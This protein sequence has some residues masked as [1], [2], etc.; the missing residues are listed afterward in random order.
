MLTLSSIIF[1][2]A[3]ILPASFQL[4]LA[5]F[6]GHFLCDY[7]LQGAFLAS[8]K[9]RHTKNADTSC[10]TP[11]MWIHALTAHSF[12]HGGMVWI[13]TGHC[14]LG[15]MEIALHWLIDFGKSEKWYSLNT[16]QMLHLACKCAYCLWIAY[17]CAA[18]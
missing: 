1:D 17:Y 12:I 10:D 7:P 8:A 18:L 13:V 6:I 15:I 16:D 4:L 9:N 3:C 2:Q 11:S 14:I 5:L